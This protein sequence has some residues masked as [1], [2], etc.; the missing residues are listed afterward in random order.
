VNLPCHK[1]E[2][3][4]HL[5]DFPSP[6]AYCHNYGTEEASGFTL[7]ELLILI[8]IV[9]IL[10]T[11]I[12]PTLA[13]ALDSANRTKCLN[14]MK[15]SMQGVLLF[16][17]D[18]D[19]RLPA[20]YDPSLGGAQAT[21]EQQIWSYIA[22]GSPYLA[23]TSPFFRCP[24]AKLSGFGFAMNHVAQTNY[25]SSTALWKIRIPAFSKPS[26]VIVLAEVRPTSASLN[27]ATTGPGHVSADFSRHN[28]KG[29]Y[30]FLDGR[31]ESLAINQVNSTDSN[32]FVAP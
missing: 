21:W 28:G 32:L 13:N 7:I 30:A 11:L 15:Q 8:A 6:D 23:Y 29:N 27:W 14:N 24:S 19:M 25:G 18:N 17:Q 9:G 26:H 2:N 22:Q 1:P 3:Q 12:I 10:A 31:V 5:R 4:S 20:G 16:A